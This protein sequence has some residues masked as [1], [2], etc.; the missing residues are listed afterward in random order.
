M[1]GF[2]MDDNMTDPDLLRP[3]YNKANAAANLADPLLD[4]TANL[5]VAATYQRMRVEIDAA[6][7]MNIFIDKALVHTQ[8]LALTAATVVMP[9]V[10]LAVESGTTILNA[11]VKQFS[12]WGNRS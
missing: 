8:L 11:T 5:A 12:C 4:V 7:N 3:I 1:A 6:G 10:M 9:V 2:G